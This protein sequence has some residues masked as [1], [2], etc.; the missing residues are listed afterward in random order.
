MSGRDLSELDGARCEVRLYAEAIRKHEER[1]EV[2]RRAMAEAMTAAR[3]YGATL[4]QLGQDAGLSS[5][6]VRQ[7]VGAR[8][9]AEGFELPGAVAIT[10]AGIF[11][12]GARP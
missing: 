3:A 6:R 1:A 5:E 4:G 9:D 11:P 10:A 8:N 7:I 2:A 12:A